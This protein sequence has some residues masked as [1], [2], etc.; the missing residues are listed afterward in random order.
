MCK[1]S[2]PCSPLCP[3]ALQKIHMMP[4]NY[5]IRLRIPHKDRLQ[6][7]YWSLNPS[8]QYRFHSNYQ[9]RKHPRVWLKSFST[10]GSPLTPQ[11]LGV[12]PLLVSEIQH[13]KLKTESPRAFHL[14]AE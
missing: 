9:I 3:Q 2:I 11:P 10:I 12:L 4:C 7:R 6:L 13:N 1:F 14:S 5:I 8:M